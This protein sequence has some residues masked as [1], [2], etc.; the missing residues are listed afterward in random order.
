LQDD[1]FSTRRAEVDQL[2]AQHANY[3]SLSYA[4]QGK[5]R[6]SVKSMF[7]DLKAQ[8]NTLPT[9]DYIAARTFLNSLL[10][11]STKSTLG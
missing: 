3:G 10:Y 6:T 4:D 8:I 9:N 11:A 1:A 2:M 5:M 7:K